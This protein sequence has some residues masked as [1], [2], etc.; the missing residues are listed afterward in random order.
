MTPA[1]D[2]QQTEKA[3]SVLVQVT[4]IVKGSVE[5]HFTQEKVT[6]TFAATA[7]AGGDMAG[8]KGEETRYHLEL[9]PWGAI[10]VPKVSCHE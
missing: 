5:T 2:F 4:N 9:R 3:M 1:F 6:L 10:T 8:G 7:A